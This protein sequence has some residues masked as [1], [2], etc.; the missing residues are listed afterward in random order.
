MHACSK[1]FSLED[2][3]TLLFAVLLQIIYLFCYLQT[4]PEVVET[5]MWCGEENL[6]SP[7]PDFLTWA[8]T[9]LEVFRRGQQVDR[10][11]LIILAVEK[12]V[13]NCTVLLLYMTAYILVDYKISAPRFKA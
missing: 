9:S 4:A 7:T 2:L 10:I 12:R 5:V 1:K 11:L 3:F 6:M 13:F 8:Y